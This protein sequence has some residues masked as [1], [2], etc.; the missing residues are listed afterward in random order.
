TVMQLL[1]RR[2]PVRVAYNASVF[3]LG[4]AGAGVLVER[5]DHERAATLVAAVGL[6]AALDYAVN[7]LLI[8]LVISVDSR[9]AFRALVAE[10]L[11]WTALPFALMASA[12]LVLVV[13]WQRTPYLVATLVGPLVAI[14]LYQRSSYRA[15]S[16]IRLAQTDPLT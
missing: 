8:A 9:R 1:E 11:R 10:S 14:A 4:A 15:L 5:L 7:V 6:A 13:L 2:A 12:S 16:A 3:A